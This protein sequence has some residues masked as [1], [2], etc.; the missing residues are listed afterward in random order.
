MTAD[1]AEVAQIDPKTVLGCTEPRLWTPPLRELTPETSYGF[2][3]IEFA[4]SIGRPLD[5]WQE[6]AVIHACELLEDGRPRFRKVLVL[7]ARQNGKTELLVILSLFWLFVQRV[8]LVLGMS[9]KVEYAAESWRKACRLAMRTEAL[10]REVPDKGGIRKAN[11]EQ[12]LWRATPAEEAA[13]EGSRYKIAAANDE[14]GR[15]LSIDRLIMDELRQQFDYSAHD[16]AVPAMA[17]RPHAQAFMIS[18]AGSDRSVVLNDYRDAALRFIERGEGDPRLGLFEWSCEANADPLDLRELAK[19]NPNLGRRLDPEALLNDAKVAVAKG[20]AKLAGFKTEH[21]CINVPRLD[22][23]IDPDAWSA[24]YDPA[25]LDEHRRKLAFCVDVS[26]DEREVVLTAA[27][28]LPDGRVRIEPVAAW[29]SVA[30]ARRE[31]RGLVER[32]KPRVF[33]WLPDGPGALFGADLSNLK[34]R[35]WPPPGVKVMPI[36]D[37]LASVCMGLAQLVHDGQLAHSGDPLLDSQIATAERLRRGDRWVF[38]R[39]GDG[40][41]AAV[42]SAAGAAY[43][44]QTLPEATSEIKVYVAQ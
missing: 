23:A 21:M 30:E 13:D 44:A 38:T 6:W 17:A 36:R 24:G 39:R 40:N 32:N 2:Q 22:P 37:E 8:A 10:K 5:P 16:A 29:D 26:L 19:A 25:P 35:K 4:K 11:G 18:N 34:G 31:V 14:G 28:R 20:G 43:L 15:S 12:T 27:A 3:V 41:T 1:V 42:Y 33:G 7:V 9:T